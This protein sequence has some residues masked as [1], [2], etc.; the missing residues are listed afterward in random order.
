MSKDGTDR[1][2]TIKIEIFVFANTLLLINFIIFRRKFM[3]YIEK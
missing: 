3:N 1:F 2:A